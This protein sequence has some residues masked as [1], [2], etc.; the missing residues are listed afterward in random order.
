MQGL[1]RVLNTSEYALV[2]TRF[3]VQYGQYFPSFPH[4]AELLHKPLDK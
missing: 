2:I 3:Q 1:H 4:F